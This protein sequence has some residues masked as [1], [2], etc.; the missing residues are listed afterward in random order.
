MNI[1][2][3]LENLRKNTEE[4]LI[5]FVPFVIVY[6]YVGYYSI[7]SIKVIIM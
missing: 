3:F 2:C 4:K 5:R 6:Y 7:D 1:I